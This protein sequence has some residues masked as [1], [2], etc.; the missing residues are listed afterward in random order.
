QRRHRGWGR[1]RDAPHGRAGGAGGRLGGG[2]AR[3][4]ARPR[5]AVVGGAGPHGGGGAGGGVDEGAVSRYARAAAPEVRHV[6]CS[7]RVRSVET[8]SPRAGGP[9][10]SR[11]APPESLMSRPRR[12][13][14]AVRLEAQKLVLAPFAFQ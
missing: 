2:A 5:R 4:A 12:S 7:K 8:T 11:R 6:P 13:L 1:G 3:A 9:K 10:G 14:E